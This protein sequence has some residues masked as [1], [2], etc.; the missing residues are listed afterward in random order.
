MSTV[1]SELVL[2][3]AASGDVILHLVNEKPAD[4][5]DVSGVLC[6]RSGEMKARERRPDKP[7][8]GWTLDAAEVTCVKC[9]EWMHA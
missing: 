3:M 9:L 1:V 5:Q 4:K 7:L 8:H 6:V 2:R